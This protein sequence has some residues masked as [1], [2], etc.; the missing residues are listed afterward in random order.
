MVV[1]RA[2][3]LLLGALLAQPRAPSVGADETA[4]APQATTITAPRLS[5]GLRCV[6][7]LAYILGLPLRSGPW[8][9]A[10]DRY[11]RQDSLSLGDVQRAGALVGLRLLPRRMSA[12]ELVDRGEPAI[13]HASEGGGHFGV[14]VDALNGNVR[15]L[16]QGV[17]AVT[18]LTR[19]AQTFSGHCLIPYPSGDKPAPGQRPGPLEL[20]CEL[21]PVTAGST[22]THSFLWRNAGTAP[23]QLCV[24]ATSRDCR[25]TIRGQLPVRPGETVELELAGRARP[26]RLQ[27]VAEVVTTDPLKPV[28][29]VTLRARCPR[30]VLVY[31]EALRIVADRQRPASATVWVSGPLDLAVRDATARPK[32]LQVQLDPSAASLR[33]SEDEALIPVTIRLDSGTPL[34]RTAGEVTIKTSDP[35]TPVIVVPVE[36]EVRGRVRVELPTLFFGFV[37]AGRGADLQLPVAAP[38]APDF[39][40]QGVECDRTELAATI[41][42]GAPGGPYTIT[43]SVPPNA[44]LGV[45]EGTLTITTNVPGEERIAIPV[46]AHVVEK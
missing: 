5:C 25:V 32:V 2:C 40:V 37:P 24:S 11:G 31:P 3:L 26:P 27:L 9:S 35:R 46:Y 14:L 33:D 43:V 28:A 16:D 17:L 44:P 6:A 45:T 10:I 29:Y 23:V 19:F 30:P 15:C 12:Q 8:L 39:R 36:L 34:P 21:P 13:V 18:P 41:T 38:S 42:G 22:A 1:C 7:D 20:D 4:A